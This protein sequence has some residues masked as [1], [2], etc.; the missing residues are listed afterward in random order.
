MTPPPLHVPTRGSAQAPL[1]AVL[2][3]VVVGVGALAFLLGGPGSESQEVEAVEGDASALSPELATEAGRSG[4]AEIVPPP[5]VEVFDWDEPTTVLWPARVELDLLRA[6]Y[7]PEEAG[8]D[9]IGS[10]RTARLSGRLA[11]SNE[12]GVEGEVRFVAGPNEGRVLTCDVTGSFGATDPGAPDPVR[13]TVLDVLLALALL[14]E[15]G[16]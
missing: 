10:G 1:L 12:G 14:D 11:H 2:A 13:G 9:P 15:R 7:L 4:V 8:V 6:D 3:L 5:R 16:L